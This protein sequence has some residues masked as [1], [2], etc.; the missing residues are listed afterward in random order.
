MFGATA[1]AD[2]LLC[3][4]LGEMLNGSKDAI[5]KKIRE[6]N[7]PSNVESQMYDVI[8][9]TIYKVFSTHD[10]E[11]LYQAAERFLL[12]LLDEKMVSVESIQTCLQSIANRP[13]DEKFCKSFLLQMN[14]EIAKNQGLTNW[15]FVNTNQEIL[16]YLKSDVFVNE[17]L[18]VLG[19]YV[20]DLNNTNYNSLTPNSQ[21]QLT[22]IVLQDDK[23]YYLNKWKARLFLHT[24]EG[25][26]PLTL[27]NTFISPEYKYYKEKENDNLYNDLED[28]LKS[29]IKENGENILSIF[30]VPGMGKTSIVA[31]LANTY[32]NNN[33]FIFLKFKSLN[34]Y[35]KGNRR[36]LKGI[37]ELLGCLERDLKKHVLVL[38]GFDEL[39]TDYNKQELL[40]TFFLD[41]KDI[42]EF[43]VI[44]TSRINYIDNSL[45]KGMSKNSI[46]LIQY[47]ERK[48]SDYQEN[49]LG[50]PLYN[51]VLISKEIVG[52]PVILYMALTVG[53]DISEENSK[54]E[55]Y[56][57]IF[58]L[59]SGIWDRFGSYDNGA[60]LVEYD[61]DKL[62]RLMQLLAFE[63]FENSEQSICMNE[64]KQIVNKVFK[65]EVD[66]N[67]VFDFPISNM[68]EESNGIEFVHKSIYEFFVAE[69]IYQEIIWAYETSEKKKLA[70]VL[71]KTLKR[72]KIT[73]EISEYLEHKITDIIDKDF[74]IDTFKLMCRDGMTYYFDEKMRR[75]IDCERNVFYN[76]LEIL[77]FFDISK[78]KIYIGNMDDLKYYCQP[79]INFSGVLFF[80]GDEFTD[81][82]IARNLYSKISNVKL[83][84]MVNL[85]RVNLI[86]ANLRDA[87]LVVTNLRDAELSF[88]DF[89]GAKLIGS[90]LTGANLREAILREADLSK[91][92][93][94]QVNLVGADITGAI[95]TKTVFKGTIFDLKNIKILEKLRPDV[96]DVFV[97]CND[98]RIT[99]DEYKQLEKEGKLFI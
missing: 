13:I 24:R 41:I 14:E 47:S 39:K 77:H 62:H 68:Y 55:L 16:R 36:L 15:I 43:K 70:S 26:K 17:I 9:K 91:T 83:N 1:F 95:L 99:Y 37:C 52:I 89:T 34:D 38:D 85:K 57:K 59:E 48:I 19:S 18:T 49:I 31:Y 69:Y 50:M 79:R 75:I 61:K 93:L 28:K 73:P 76:V 45:L 63:M 7:H 20:K 40:R 54:C 23:Q 66:S 56:E 32:S 81:A 46:E 90:V 53:I 42:I 33:K 72:N 6:R 87:I 30:G 44:I 10:E 65:E 84:A 51:C 12:K 97:E 11:S 22:D 58:S 64:Y 60:H 5:S 98:K 67:I 71:G 92:L 21:K 94:N 96:K 2:S 35:I 3:L 86:L 82:E 88:A 74:Y 29:F 4:A 8:L 27:E 80:D 78:Y 25:D